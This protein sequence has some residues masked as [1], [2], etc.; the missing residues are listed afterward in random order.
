M[1]HIKYKI[2]KS[3]KTDIKIRQAPFATN[4]IKYTVALVRTTSLLENMMKS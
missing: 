3:I 4:N 2:K 1:C